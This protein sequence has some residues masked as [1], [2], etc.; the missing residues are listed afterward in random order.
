MAILI[1]ILTLGLLVFVHELGHFLVARAFGISVDE[2][3]FGF[4]PRIFGIKRGN[5]V[6]SINWIPLGGFVK[7]KGVAG[8]DA[9]KERFADSD[10]FAA[11]RTWKKFCVLAAGIVMNILLGITLL[12]VGFRIGLPLSLEQDIPNATTRN[13]QIQILSI[14]S[15]SPAESVGLQPGDA[16]VSINTA[17]F[18][19]TDDVR[20]FLAERPGQEI[21]LQWKRKETVREGTVRLLNQEGRGMLGVSLGKIGI[22]SFSLPRAFLMGAQTSFG[23]AGQIFVALA[24]VLRG[25][26]VEHTVRPDLSGPIGIAVMTGQAARLGFIYLLQFTAILSVNLA[27]FNVL[28]IPALDGGRI[29]FVLIERVRR[30]P[31]NERIE[32]LIHNTGFVFLLALVLLVTARDVARFKDVLFS[33]FHKLF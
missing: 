10:S 31:L 13:A 28:P 8:D 6:Y 7:I 18:L 16:L 22:V 19:S 26:V 20:N 24:D 33:F 32:A 11:A 5:T 1:F 3:G 2:F 23:M 29:L 17:T 9:A 30:K 12:T 4:P 25:L 27:V 21:H 14:Q 15:P